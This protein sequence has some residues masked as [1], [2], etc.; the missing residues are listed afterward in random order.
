MANKIY[1]SNAGL[2]FTA[3]LVHSPAEERNPPPAHR[4]D[5][6]SLQKVNAGTPSIVRKRSKKKKELEIDSSPTALALRDGVT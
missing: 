3:L 5:L 2:Y 1:P 4:G 6:S